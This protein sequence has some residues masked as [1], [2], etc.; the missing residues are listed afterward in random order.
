[1][2]SAVSSAFFSSSDQWSEKA[3]YS[4][5]LTAEGD[6][7]N[8]TQVA[9]W[10]PYSE[11][12]ALREQLNSQLA[13]SGIR[14]GWA[15]PAYGIQLHA[16][17]I[18][19]TPMA[20]AGDLVFIEKVAP[21]DGYVLSEVDIYRRFFTTGIVISA[22]SRGITIYR[23][24][25]GISYKTPRN[26]HVVSAG[27]VNAEA[28]LQMIASQEKGCG[29]FKGEFARPADALHLLVLHQKIQNPV[30]PKQIDVV[31]DQA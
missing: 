27:E 4:I 13:S 15:S 30:Y 23:D 14:R 28:L 24:R 25:D 6:W 5:Y 2:N 20:K 9:S 10:L 31:M 7:S 22:G 19:K 17:E 18:R 21:I 29:W 12:H 8:R 1:M 11:A 3:R 26:S 16:P